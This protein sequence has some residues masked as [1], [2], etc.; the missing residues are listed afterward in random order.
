VQ[1]ELLNAFA[2]G[3]VDNPVF[4]GGTG[5]GFYRKARP[6]RREE[7]ETLFSEPWLWRENR[8]DLQTIGSYTRTIRRL[9][10]AE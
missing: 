6:F 1:I 4:R 3:L 2:V 5:S 7:V 10:G 8:S 9:P